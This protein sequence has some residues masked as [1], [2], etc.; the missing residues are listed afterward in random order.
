MFVITLL[1]CEKKLWKA[2]KKDPVLN[3]L[4]LEIGEILKVFHDRKDLMKQQTEG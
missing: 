2:K 1:N 3:F 4:E